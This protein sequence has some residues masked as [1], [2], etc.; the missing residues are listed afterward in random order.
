M[1]YDKFWDDNCDRCEKA[2]RIIEAC[3]RK[4]KRLNC[5]HYTPP[6]VIVDCTTVNLETEFYFDNVEAVLGYL[7]LQSC[8][9]G[10][11]FSEGGR[12]CQVARELVENA[13]VRIDE[14]TDGKVTEKEIVP[15]NWSDLIV[16]S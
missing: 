5:S 13:L 12:G 7:Q 14:L 8:Y 4:L 3:N 9:L 16:R 10:C 6:T 15:R 1:I 11:H 2:K